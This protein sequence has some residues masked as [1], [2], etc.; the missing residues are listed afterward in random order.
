MND[1]E[2][3]SFEKAGVIRAERFAAARAQELQA[4]FA[5]LP[6]GTAPSAA[7]RLA[8]IGAPPARMLLRRRAA[9]FRPYR[10]PLFLRISAMKRRKLPSGA[11]VHVRCRACRRATRLLSSRQR[12]HEAENHHPARLRWL[13]THLWHSKRMKMGDFFGYRV[14]LERADAGVRAAVRWAR[15][16]ATIY[17]E[18]YHTCFQFSGSEC[19]LLRL[20]GQLSP[21]S[22]AVSADCQAGGHEIEVMMYGLSEGGGAAAGEILHGC[23]DAARRPI[24][25]VRVLWKPDSDIKGLTQGNDRVL[26]MF[27]HPAAAQELHAAAVHFVRTLSLHISCADLRGEM[28]RFQ[29]RHGNITCQEFQPVGVYECN[30]ILCLS[31]RLWL[32]SST[33]GSNRPVAFSRSHPIAGAGAL[34]T[35]DTLGGATPSPSGRYRCVRPTKGAGMAAH[36]RGGRSSMRRA[37]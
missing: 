16:C 11:G 3:N 25:P 33:L 21:R 32:M 28:A 6:P 34:V 7:A 12:A 22:A 26:W 8:R 36:G 13:A 14:A 31:F 1:Q 24:A 30:V 27:I 29:V 19:E 4:A 23:C 9:S 15:N 18:S 5:A 37:W 20:L 2:E 17:D 35:G 10:M